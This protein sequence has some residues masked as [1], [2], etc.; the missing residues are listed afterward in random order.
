M[1]LV[2]YLTIIIHYI[3]LP[4]SLYHFSSL[5]TRGLRSFWHSLVIF[6]SQHL[7]QSGKSPLRLI[8]LR[9]PLRS[10]LFAAH[11]CIWLCCEYLQHI[12]VF[13]CGA[14]ICSTCAV[15]LSLNLLVLFLFPCVFIEAHW[16]RLATVV[17]FHASMIQ[18]IR[19]SIFCFVFSLS[20]LCVSLIRGEVCQG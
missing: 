8:F 10:V 7:S 12:S 17:F 5:G 14:S 2:Y 13:G 11:F 15:K 6:I 20:V 4:L 3:T 18:E 9:A 19:N 16:A 1:H